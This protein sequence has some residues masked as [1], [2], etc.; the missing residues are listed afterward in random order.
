MKY[1]GTIVIFLAIF[2]CVP[3]LR[4]NVYT[5]TDEKGVK[6]YSN[7]A[8]SESADE[9][10]QDKEIPLDTSPQ[11]EQKAPPQKI[12][13]GENVETKSEKKP[14]PGQKADEKTAEGT[15][16][17]GL[18]LGSLPTNQGELVAREKNIVKQLQLD[19]EK[20]ESKRQEFIDREKK[21]LM[22]TL[23]HIRRAPVSNFGS[24]K[25]KT[26]QVGYVQYRLDALLNAPDTYFQY[27]DSDAD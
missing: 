20:D 2:L 1:P 6:H 13:A 22:Q 27:G 3:L 9:I 23:E 25:N 24:S 16:D 4:A 14:K 5:W 17:S 8:P 7:V 10:Q 19:L 18:N 12:D 15:A 21:R 11:Q 26:R